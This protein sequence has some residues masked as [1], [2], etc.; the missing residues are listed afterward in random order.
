MPIECPRCLHTNADSSTTCRCGYDSAPQLRR[1]QID[2]PTTSTGEAP[3]PAALPKE[4]RKRDFLF[5]I[6]VIWIALSIGEWV[7]IRL[8]L[9]TRPAFELLKDSLLVGLTDLAG[10]LFV[11][12]LGWVGVWF[13]LAYEGSHRFLCPK[14]VTLSVTFLAA[15]FLFIVARV[16]SPALLTQHLFNGLLLFAIA[17][18]S[19]YAG[20]RGWF[21]KW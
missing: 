21:G 2:S 11:G 3:T 18:F 10:A 7:W 15:S 5:G 14:R 17:G 19:Y 4:M 20:S 12:S 8:H 6:G 13:L 9:P 16:T 1:S